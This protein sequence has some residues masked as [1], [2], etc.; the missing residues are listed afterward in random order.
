MEMWLRNQLPPQLEHGA[1][2]GVPAG[3]D[4][5]LEVSYG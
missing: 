4:S 1:G 5:R 3:S 2:V